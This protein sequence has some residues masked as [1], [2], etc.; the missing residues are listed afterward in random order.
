MALVN[1]PELY[2]RRARKHFQP[3]IVAALDVWWSLLFNYQACIAQCP[4]G[5]RNCARCF[6]SNG[7]D[8]VIR[9]PRE[10]NATK[11][12]RFSFKWIFTERGKQP[13]VGFKAQTPQ[14]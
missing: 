14:K 12:K 11:V 13:V 10:T 7:R 2:D 8:S 9:I 5:G 1:S 6:V 4:C 3:E